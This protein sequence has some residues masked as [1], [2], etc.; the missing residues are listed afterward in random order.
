[1]KSVMLVFYHISSSHFWLHLNTAIT[2]VLRIILT[3]S[4]LIY[5]NAIK[6]ELPWSKFFNKIFQQFV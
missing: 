4:R 3:L 6:K 1:M 5:K 2:M